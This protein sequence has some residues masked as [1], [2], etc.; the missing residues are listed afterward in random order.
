MPWSF[1]D[2]ARLAHYGLGVILQEQDHSLFLIVCFQSSE[3]A[4]LI[5][6]ACD[7]LRHV[8]SDLVLIRERP[9][10]AVYSPDE[11]RLRLASGVSE[12]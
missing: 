2:T 7:V 6:T 4:R 10:W 1:T 8:R 11:R 12:V 5:S 3:V 9:G